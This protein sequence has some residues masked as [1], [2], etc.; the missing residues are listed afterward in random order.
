MT[1]GNEDRA[2]NF[3]VK[4]PAIGSN[5][6]FAEQTGIVDHAIVHTSARND[7]CCIIFDILIGIKCTCKMIFKINKCIYRAKLGMAKTAHGCNRI[8]KWVFIFA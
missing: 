1:A 8:G 3:V 7:Q 6:D 4:T 5:I 2:I